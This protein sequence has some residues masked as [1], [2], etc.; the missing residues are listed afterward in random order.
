MVATTVAAVRGD[1]TVTPLR[2]AGSHLAGLVTGAS[3]FFFAAAAVGAAAPTPGRGALMALGIVV[4]AVG[5]AG[6]LGASV[7]VLSS[8]KQVPKAWSR[9]MTPA[10]HAF[11]YGVGLGMGVLTRI[12][13]W[14][15]HVLL[16]VILI[17]ADV[18]VALVAAALYAIG[19]AIPV[20]VSA[21]R[22]DPAPA[23][24]DA[25]DRARPVAFRIDG[26]VVAL[27]GVALLARAA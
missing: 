1:P 19:R 23:F 17:A 25:I 5:A 24:V 8:P 3:A 22:D 21:G 7:R 9:T 14:S 13:T 26:V 20:A 6:A 15:L 4:L 16:L 11:A 10:E 18:R 27:A 2:M 12:P